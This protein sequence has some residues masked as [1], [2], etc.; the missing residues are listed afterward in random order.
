MAFPPLFKGQNAPDLGM[1]D[2]TIDIRV[3]E[4]QLTPLAPAFEQLAMHVERTGSGLLVQIVDVLR[5]EKET[6]A[7]SALQGCQRSQGSISRKLLVE[8]AEKLEK[9]LVSMSLIA[10]TNDPTL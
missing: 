10:M 2:L 1:R 4:G 3:V 7:Q 8:L 9:L 5:A 6:R